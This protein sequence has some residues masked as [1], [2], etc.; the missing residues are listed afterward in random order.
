MDPEIW[1]FSRLAY[2]H[3]PVGLMPA[4]RTPLSALVTHQTHAYALHNLLTPR[5]TDT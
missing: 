2:S 1:H 5:R 4:I 3:M